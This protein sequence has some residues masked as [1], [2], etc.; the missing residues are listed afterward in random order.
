VKN[1]L[2]T[3][4]K[5]FDLSNYPDEA[6]TYLSGTPD[7]TSSAEKYFKGVPWLYRGV[8]IRAD[9]IASMP[10]ALFRGDTEFDKSDDWQNKVGFIP[11]PG[12]LWWL[13]EACLTLEGKAYLFSDN[14]GKARKLLRYLRPDGM[15]PVFSPDTGQLM[16]FKRNKAAKGVNRNEF[17]PVRDVVYFWHD[18]PYVETGAG[19][20]MSS[21]GKAA[22]MASGVIANVDEFM[23]GFFKR[24]LI[25]A[26]VLGLPQGTPKEEKDRVENFF[27]NFLSGI[28]N[29]GRVK[30]INAD[31][32]T[33]NVV[34]DGLKELQVRDLTDVQREDI[35][36]ALGIPH[37]LLFSQASNFAT[38]QQDDLHFYSKTIV[39][40]CRFIESVLN[41]QVFEP[42][43]LR[44][45][46]LEQSM[47]IFQEDEE[48]RAE[49]VSF[50]IDFAIKCPTFELFMATLHTY[51]FEL[52][53]DMEAAAKAYYEQKE[54][55]R[56]EMRQMQM[57]AA[58][59]PEQNPTTGNNPTS[60]QAEL[61]KWERKAIKSLERGKAANVPFESEVIPLS[62]SG[63]ISGALEAARTPEDVKQVF[64]DCERWGVY[65]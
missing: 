19:E 6:W 63:A 1:Y 34:G 55:E 28:K 47:D 40:E 61:R 43:G 58:Q 53:P 51:G 49:S 27:N 23:A 25:K 62:L 20:P 52:S 9:A 18:D 31:A 33:V 22:L 38:A 65:P 64:A 41:K 42:L 56:E 29:I 39:P 7:A 30:A 44:L 3:S 37:S 24:G 26:T 46:F 48:Q 21:P 13:I 16:H 10:F 2:Y 17:E 45:E 5:S 15:T 4:T 54:A 11:D 57:D 59:E 36:T 60:V 12:R 32:V 14:V 50:F 8:T 35:S